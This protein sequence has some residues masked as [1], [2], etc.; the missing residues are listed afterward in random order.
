TSGVGTA[1]YAAPE[2]KSG[3]GYDSAADIYSLGVM[4]LEMCHPPFA[5]LMERVVVLTDARSGQ[6]GAAM[7]E[8]A[9]FSDLQRLLATMLSQR[10]A[11]RPTAA[12]V[13]RRVEALQG[14][15]MVLQ[16]ERGSVVMRVEAAE[17]EGLLRQVRETAR[18]MC[19]AAAS[20]TA[21][22]EQ[23]ALRGHDGV[24]VVELLIGGA[25]LEDREAIRAAL[26]GLPDVRSVNVFPAGA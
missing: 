20:G 6:F 4:L 5:T 16:I 14:K 19:A 26:R 17:R 10:P 9:E 3:R 15:N 24:A 11:Q 2:Q 23:Y 13:V 25:S 1:L 18:D 12:D 21:R 22:L 8:M 7:A